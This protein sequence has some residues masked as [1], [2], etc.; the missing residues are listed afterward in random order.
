MKHETFWRQLLQG[1]TASVPEPVTL[2]TE[3]VYYGDQAAVTLRADVRDT[4]YQ[5]A[6]TATVDLAIDAPGAQ[7]RTVEMQAVPGVPGRY[8]LTVDADSTGMYRFEAEANLDGEQLGRSRV[9]IRREDGVSEHF[10]VEQNRALLERLASATG[11]QYFALSDAGD[12]PEAVQYSDAGIIE[13][14]LLELWNMPILFLLLV[15]LKAGE[16]VLRLAWGRL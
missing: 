12:I 9:A 13:R 15:F 10:K 16:W 5:P 8:E 7:R 3:R 4:E 14:R 11:G 2:T 1:M 6:T